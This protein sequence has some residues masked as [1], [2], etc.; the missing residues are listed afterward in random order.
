M[1]W[2]WSRKGLLFILG[3]AVGWWLRGV[4]SGGPPT[5]YF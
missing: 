4:F 5:P 1:L 2:E 3:V